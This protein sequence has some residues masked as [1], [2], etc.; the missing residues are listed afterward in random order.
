LESS[1]PSTALASFVSEGGGPRTWTQ[2]TTIS[3]RSRLRRCSWLQTVGCEASL[4]RN[5]VSARRY[6]LQV[7]VRKRLERP[8][9]RWRVRSD[10]F[11]PERI[12]ILQMKGLMGTH[13][14][15]VGALQKALP[16]LLE[17]TVSK[18]A[19]CGSCVA[20]TAS[21]PLNA[22]CLRKHATCSI[23][24]DPKFFGPSFGYTNTDESETGDIIDDNEENQFANGRS[25]R[26]LRDGSTANGHVAQTRSGRAV[27]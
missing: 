15:R 4:R 8:R 5:P 10:L 26:D 19:Y 22:R 20:V 13:Y 14:P 3:V 12:L 2:D 9:C 18:G 21:I 24:S 7:S 16:G 1:A 11:R 25:F 27:I 23:G 17:I 6:S